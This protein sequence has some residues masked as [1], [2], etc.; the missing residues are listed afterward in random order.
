MHSSFEQRYGD[1]NLKQ[2]VLYERE[3]DAW[4]DTREDFYCAAWEEK[5]ASH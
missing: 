5:N 4:V 2:S 3:V 1:C